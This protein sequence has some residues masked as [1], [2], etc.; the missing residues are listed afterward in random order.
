MGV[1]AILWLVVLVVCGALEVI[2]LVA[3][4]HGGTLSDEIWAWFA[5]TDRRRAGW[6]HV[7]RVALLAAMTWLAVRFNV[8]G[9]V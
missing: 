7:R 4:R 1:L 5:G 6:T 2:A 8:T 9:H 3:E